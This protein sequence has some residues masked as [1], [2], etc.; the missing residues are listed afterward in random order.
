MHT[1][2]PTGPN[3]V[4]EVFDEEVVVVNLDTGKYY[5][6]RNTGA[7]VWNSIV[8]HAAIDEIANALINYHPNLDAAA[9]ASDI[10]L[11][12]EQ[13]VHEGLIKRTEVTSKSAEVAEPACEYIAPSMDIY[14]DMQEIL[15]LDPVHDVD[16][17]GWPIAQK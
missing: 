4:F 1:Y 5:S 14:N 13:L 17:A 16:E 9:I 8:S 2:E 10:R 7:Y 15:L 11:F 12:I 6:I 3:I